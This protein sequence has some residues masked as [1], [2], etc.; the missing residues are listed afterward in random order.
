MRAVP[1]VARSRSAIG[2]RGVHGGW[3]A[4]RLDAATLQS[5]QQGSSGEAQAASHWGAQ[6]SSLAAAGGIEQRRAFSSAASASELQEPQ[7]T[8]YQYKICPFCNKVK[9]V[10]DFYGMPYATV[11]TNP[12]SKEEIKA[13][14]ED[15]FKVPIVK[16]AEREQINDSPVILDRAIDMLHEQGKMSEAEY[17]ATRDE[18]LRKW[19]RWADEKLAVLLFQTLR[20]TLESPGKHLPILQT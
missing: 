3:L 20:G 13:F 2:M 14:S 5:D 16:T 4:G 6:H 15:Y 12:V 11:E 10:L 8:M 7:L 1:L 19:M 17:A 18:E 9:A